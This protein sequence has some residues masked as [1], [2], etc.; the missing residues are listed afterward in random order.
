MWCVFQDSFNRRET[1]SFK[2][3]DEER[4]FLQQVL[5]TGQGPAVEEWVS[6]KKKRNY[7]RGKGK[8]NSRDNTFTVLLSN[9]RGYKSKRAH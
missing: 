6:V 1:C 8:K 7:Y 4:H 9:M 3:M 5:G 2:H